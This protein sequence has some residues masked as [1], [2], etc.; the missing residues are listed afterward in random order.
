[1]EQPVARAAGLLGTPSLFQRCREA[2]Q[3]RTGEDQEELHR[4]RILGG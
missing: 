4:K 2:Q 3:R 1:M